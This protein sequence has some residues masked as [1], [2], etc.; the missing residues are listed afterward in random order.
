MKI[1]NQS[2]AIVGVFIGLGSI[3]YGQSPSKSPSIT[4]PAQVE[5]YERASIFAKA[6]GYVAA[7]NVDIGDIVEKGALL[8]ELS[9]PEMDQEHVRQLAL[10]EQSEAAIRQAESKVKSFQ[11]KIVAAKSQLAAMKA[12]YAKHTADIQFAR[13]ELSRITSLVSSRAINASMQD[14]KAQQLRSAEAAMKSAE[15]DVGSAEANILVAD[16][17]AKEAEADLAYATAQRNVSKASLAQ[18]EALMQYAKI[19]APFAG[20]ITQRGVDPGDFVVSAVSAKADP[21]FRLN[22]ID[23]LRIVFSVPEASATQIHVGQQVELK[24]DSVKEQSFV[25]EVKRTAGELDSRT[26]TLRVE[27]EVKDDD[28]RLRSGMYGMIIIKAAAK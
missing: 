10:V 16:A 6:S 23:R 14:E 9:I 19:R 25:G 8:A 26:R 18:T 1:L 21:L 13:S 11:A 15:A 5:P 24:V 4:Q 3:G 12:Q 27:A 20:Q 7:V 2:I 17:N 22:R 28:Q